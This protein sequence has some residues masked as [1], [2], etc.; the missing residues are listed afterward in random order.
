ML[1]FYRLVFVGLIFLILHFT[2]KGGGQCPDD[3]NNQGICK[4]GNC[5]CNTG[6][7]GN[8][9]QIPPSTDCAGGCSTQGSCNTT[10]G[11]C[12]CINGYSG[13]NCQIPPLTCSKN[14]CKNNGK[15]IPLSLGFTIGNK[16]FN[17]DQY[18]TFTGATAFKDAKNFC[19]TDNSCE[20]INSIT[21]SASLLKD[22]SAISEAPGVYATLKLGGN[23]MCV[24][25]YVGL[26]CS[27][28]S[29]LCKNGNYKIIKYDKDKIIYNTNVKLTSQPKLKIPGVITCPP[30][31]VTKMSDNT[32]LGSIYVPSDGTKKPVWLMPNTVV[33]TLEDPTATPMVWV[34]NKDSNSTM[35]MTPDN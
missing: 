32:S 11:K 17:G 1:L 7:S 15:C 13:S 30:L 31:S 21:N 12:N 2:N 5:V 29:I 14:G 19:L 16:R 18:K 23:C 26:D 6:Y 22:I 34:S 9:C 25:S 10:T 27:Y 28:V 35:V 24:N 4:D 3:C 33:Y 20:G 8:N